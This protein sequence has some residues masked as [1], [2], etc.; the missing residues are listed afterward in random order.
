MATRTY[1]GT[2]Q[3]SGSFSSHAI[4]TAASDRKVVVVA[5]GVGDDTTDPTATIGGNAAT[6][7]AFTIGDVGEGSWWWVAVFSL[8]VPSGTTANIVISHGTTATVQIGVYALYGADAAADS[9]TSSTSAI[10]SAELDVDTENGGIVVGGGFTFA[11]GIESWTGVTQDDTDTMGLGGD[12]TDGAYYFASHAASSSE[13]P[14]TVDANFFGDTFS[15]HVLAMVSYPPASGGSTIEADGALASQAADVDGTVGVRVNASGTPTSTASDVD[16]TVGVTINATGALV[17]QASSIA[18]VANT[19]IFTGALAAQSAAISGTVG[20][21]LNFSGSL[22]AQAATLAGAV[23]VTVNLNGA[24]ASQASTTEGEATTDSQLSVDG[25]L[26]AQN[27]AISGAVDATVNASGTLSTSASQISGSVGVTA[28]FSGALA[29]QAATLVGVFTAQQPA[30][31]GALQAQ[32]A[33][34]AGTAGISINVNG[35]LQA[36]DADI[37]VDFPTPLPTIQFTSNMQSGPASISGV[38]SKVKVDRSDVVR[39]LQRGR[40]RFK[41]RAR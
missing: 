27:A 12:L 33:V 2:S 15:F 25:A 11:G 39:V 38:F 17:S 35:A 34:I 21:T 29:A 28:N 37:F 18:G 24:L 26:Q 30:V 16:G 32:S 4:G 1:V 20:I 14:R 10:P 36:Q 9:N 23:G 41:V 22:A 8:D 40:F 13:T 19:P 3:G 7:D 6:R 31:S 5:V